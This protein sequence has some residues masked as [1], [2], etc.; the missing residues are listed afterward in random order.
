[1]I[2]GG[3]IGGLATG[4]A[5][6]QT[7]WEI[8]IFERTAELRE[9]GAGLALWSGI[10]SALRKLGVADDVIARGGPLERS[11]TLSW[12][13]EVLGEL[14]VREILPPGLEP[15]VCLHRADLHGALLRALPDGVV[16]LNARCVGFE[17]DE[18][19]VAV[20][21]A[22]GRTERGDLLI[23]ADGLHSAV[24]AQ[25]VGQAKPRY[26]GYTC[27]RGIAP[28][29]TPNVHGTLSESWGRGARFGI[30]DIGRGKVLW[31]AT[32]NAP[33]G[34]QEPLAE[35]KR[36]LIE[37]FRGWH[38]S[39]GQALEATP[40]DTIIRNDIY[41]REPIKTWGSGRVTL[42]GDA[43]HPTTPNLGM[44]ACMAIEDAL[45]VASKLQATAD[46]PT[47]LRAYE[48]FRRDRTARITRLSWQFG[49]VAQWAN[50]LACAARNQLMKRTPQSVL[51]SQLLQ[52]VTY[53]VV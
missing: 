4:L 46:I 22:D 2:V 24:R 5:L 14:N 45:V 13:G 12:R 6:Q 38:E 31:F 9:V 33:E 1:L 19:G 18:G 37:R 28:L 44:G 11:Q 8:A 21:L 20:R 29:D 15:S 50:P 52:V 26:A 3:G 35:R 25:L 49:W 47:A 40:D 48:D 7:G 39:V 16:R 30:G 43:A 36:Q 42:L 41:D 51:R 27:W 17:Q 23:G 34:E 32:A 53:R 10:M